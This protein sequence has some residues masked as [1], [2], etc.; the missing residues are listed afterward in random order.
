MTATSSD[1]VPTCQESDLTNA[2]LSDSDLTNTNLHGAILTGV[3]LSGAQLNGLK[4]GQVTG[5]PILPTE[6][7]ITGGY[8]VGPG[9]DLKGAF[10]SNVSLAGDNLMGV[11][12]TGANLYN[13]DLTNA[14]LNTA[15]LTGVSSTSIIGAPHAPDRLGGR[16]W[17]PRGSQRQSL[18]RLYGW[19]FADRA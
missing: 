1:R 2:N 11:N 5:A 4:S 7:E 13:V 18:W 6:W 12:L 8:I 15:T 14:V 19:R 3:D 17:I 16:F 9:A 10:L